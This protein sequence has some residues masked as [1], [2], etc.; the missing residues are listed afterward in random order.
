PDRKT[1]PVDDAGFA[2]LVDERIAAG[3]RDVAGHDCCST[4]KRHSGSCDERQ[5][6]NAYSQK[7]RTTVHFSAPS[8]ERCEKPVAN[9]FEATSDFPHCAN[10]SA[11]LVKTSFPSGLQAK[12]PLIRRFRTLNDCNAVERCRR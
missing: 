8:P 11:T 4:R 12:R 10:Q 7:S 5:T 9:C 3:N 1:A 6:R 2:A